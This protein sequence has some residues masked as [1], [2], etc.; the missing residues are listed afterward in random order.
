[1]YTKN[2]IA[3]KKRHSTTKRPS[4]R[5]STT[6]RPSKRRS[7]N[8][9]PSKRRS[10]TKRPSKRPSKR[11][12]IKKLSEKKK[13]CVRNKV[14]IVMKEFKQK[15]LKTSAGKIVRNPKQGIAIAL[16]VARKTCKV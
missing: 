7:T 11:L 5:R 16:S 3:Y 2:K 1:M 10:T 8:K 15:K 12:S 6:K 14:G 13:L 4:K 9:R